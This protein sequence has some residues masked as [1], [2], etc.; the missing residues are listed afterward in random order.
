MAR[1]YNFSAGPS[2]LPEYV[3]K[4]AQSELVEYST[5]GQSVMEMSHRSKEYMTIFEDCK[6]LLRS[7]LNIP[8]EYEVLFVQGGATMQFSM[9]PM[10]FLPRTGTAD[11][12]I[13]G[14]FS[15]K[16]YQEGCRFGDVRVLASS[17]EDNFSHIPSW[18]DQTINPEASYLHICQNNTIYG[19]RFTTL[20]NTGNV[21]LVADLSSCILSE[22]IDVSKY[23]LIYAGAQKNMG[24]AGVCVV[25]VRKDLIQEPIANTPV[26][27]DYRTYLENDSM[28][29]TPPTYAIYMIKL[30]LEWIR[31]QVGGLE[32]MKEINEQKAAVLYHYLDR[33]NLFKGTAQ[34]PDRSLMN[35][36]FVTGDEQLDKEFCAQAQQAGFYNLKGHRSVGGMRASI[37]NAMPVQG[38]EKLVEFMQTFEQNHQ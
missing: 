6:S 25:I 36:T 15:K 24:P 2:T 14:Q 16:A 10:N 32:K 8:D 21:P 12:I 22:P 28:Y 29:N 11:Y 1:I 38:I 26:L 17:E 23:A 18:S 30:V 35:V 33:S 20:P 34:K 19:T 7:T 3:L 13:S 4:Q 9:I 5:S 31:D 27:L 37:Y